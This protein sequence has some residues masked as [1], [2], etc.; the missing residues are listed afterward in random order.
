MTFNEYQQHARETAVYPYHGDNI[1]YPALGLIGE[2]AEVSEKIKKY[3][4]LEG[5]LSPVELKE[6]DRLLIVKELGDVLWY[7][8]AMC[9]EIDADMDFVATFNLEKLHDRAVNKT[10]KGEGDER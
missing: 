7:V 9:S 3:W 1:V 8:A 10:L 4:R 6:S 5:T 2:A